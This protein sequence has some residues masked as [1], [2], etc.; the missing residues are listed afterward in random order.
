MSASLLLKSR[1]RIFFQNTERK[2]DMET[3][4]VARF[5]SRVGDYA[6]YRPT[7]PR[8]VV[9]LLA[10]ECGLTPASRVADVGS[11]TGLSSEL[12][13]RNGNLVY[14][15]EPN[16]EM[17]EAGERL[18]V[19]FDN[20]VSVD[21]R[22]EAT[23][24]PDE[25]VDFIVAG[26]AF[27]WFDIEGARREFERVL[28]PGGWVVVVWNERRTDSTPFLIAYERMLLDY[29]TDY[30]EVSHK[31]ADEEL[32]HPFFGADVAR[33]KIFENRQVFDIESL[34]GR[35][36]SASYTPEPGHPDFEPMMKR[37]AEIFEAHAEEGRVAFEYETKVF[38]AQMK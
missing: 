15:I 10:G 18:L 24:L 35:V 4:G 8:A 30:R 5:T 14:G 37:L 17:R 25:S 33:V 34:K 38:Y 7:Y 21:G 20:F 27:H 2:I 3:N 6:R 12:F 19:G 29:G 9:E 22:A 26:Q 32:I 36:R 16:R 1:W 28:A 11:G 23:T 13:L 31:Y